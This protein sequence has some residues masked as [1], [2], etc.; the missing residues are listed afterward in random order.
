MKK[1]HNEEPIIRLRVSSQ[2][3]SPATTQEA[4][5]PKIVLIGEQQQDHEARS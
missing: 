3:T 1:R 5:S 2:V 4:K